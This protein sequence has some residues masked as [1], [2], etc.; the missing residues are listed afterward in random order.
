MRQVDY[1]VAHELVH[2]VH[3][4]PTR[5]FWARLGRLLPD[6]ETRRDQLRRTGRPIV[7]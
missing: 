3:G 7:W 1:V 2:L 4:N 6:Y 5:V